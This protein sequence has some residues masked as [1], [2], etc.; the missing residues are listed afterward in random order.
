MPATRVGAE[1]LE[2]IAQAI[3]GIRFGSVQITIHDSK[4]VLIEKAE[5]IRVDSPDLNEG[6]PASARRHPT[7]GLEER[8]HH[9]EERHEDA[10]SGF[11]G[12][13]HGRGRDAVVGERGDGG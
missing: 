10:G 8:E 6:G 9:R 5:K 4:V 3:R 12:G 1:V 2:R 11:D 7:R 13:G